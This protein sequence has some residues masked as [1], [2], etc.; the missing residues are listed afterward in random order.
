MAKRILAFQAHP[1]DV[2][3]TCA[4]TLTRLKQE[5]GWEIIIATATSGDCGTLEY[6]PDEIARIRNGEAK[7]A[8]AILGAEYYCAASTDLL[9]MY[10]TPSLRRFTEVVRKARP[11]IIITHSPVDYLIDHEITSQLVRT[12]AFAAPAP[13]FLT[14]DPQPAKRLDHVPHLYY[15][16][17]LESK[18]WFGQRI[19]P[20]FVI[21]ITGVMD[22]K[23]KMLASHASQRNWL[24]DHHGMDEY[25]DSMKRAGTEYGKLIGKTY[26]E[27]FR[28]HLGHGYP[29]DNIIGKT[30]KA[31]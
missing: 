16:Q 26:G 22:T 20:G 10:D 2:E 1:D 14:F 17:P 11:D 12:A 30:L 31:V 25:I 13:N 15:A 4:G 24:R 6:T 19:E 23:E 9:V 27:G 5:A 3:F 28:Q 21:D 7:A 18:D 8:A 29:E